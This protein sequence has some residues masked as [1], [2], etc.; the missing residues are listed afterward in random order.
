MH[1]SNWILPRA[2]LSDRRVSGISGGYPR[3]TACTSAF[4]RISSSRMT[5]ASAQQTTRVRGTAS[6]IVEYRIRRV[7]TGEVRWLWRAIDFVRD[8]DGT[9]LKMFG[10]MQ[11]ITERKSTE[12]SLRE[13]EA[14][15]RGAMSIGRIGSWETDLVAR[16]RRWSPEAQELFGLSLPDG[17]GVVGGEHDEFVSALHPDDRH[18][19]AKFHE[20][21][22]TVNSFDAEYR[23]IRGDGALAWM[24][25]RGQVFER[26]AQGRCTR[27]INIIADVTEQKKSADHV[28]FLLQEMSHRS[29]NLLAIIQGIAR[30]TARRSGSIDDFQGRFVDRLQGLA[31]SHDLLVEQKWE[32]VEFARS[33][34]AAARIVCR[35]R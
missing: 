24:S 4:W 6:P 23:I 12:L 10:V 22:K 28:R 21:A 29:K 31:A 35:R 11:D 26:D 17:I 5:A 8:A 25:G 9:P 20:L 32:R 30:Q 3:G 33:R 2:P 7:D 14:R 18:L 15:Y 16:T 1:H 19:V 27:M 13:S 34:A